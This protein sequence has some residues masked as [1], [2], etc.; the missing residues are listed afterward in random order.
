MSTADSTLAP[1]V[2]AYTTSRRKQGTYT[3]ESLRS[4]TPRLD[5][6][7]RSFGH[8]PI[9]Q[10][11]R[12]AMER[13]LESLEHLS[14]NS[15]ASY[16]ASVREFTRW[17]AVNG[18]TATDACAEIPKAKRAKTIPRAQSA[19]RVT[20]ILA[21]A[22][23]DR[24]LA[25]VWLMLGCGL[26]RAE[27]ASLRW[28]DYDAAGATILVHG[29]G[30]KERLL[31]VPRQVARALERI[32]VAS[33]GPVIRS[34]TTGQAVLPTTIGAMMTA[35]M[36]RAGVKQAPWDGVSGHALRHTAASDVLESSGYDLRTVQA[37]LGH[38]HLSSTAIYLRRASA[39]QIRSAMDGRDY[40]DAA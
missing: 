27:V 24:E 29:K 8:R 11:G 38:E 1:Y 26:R 12:R 19:D 18:H 9:E 23:D 39:E 37:M 40:G 16:L 22:A 13:W 34:K 17:L 2:R 30:N 4:V 10:L 5:S 35:L 20:R 25:V 6:L 31:P 7:A 32:H 33:S 21:N 3:T 14:T 15:R 28:E 36:R